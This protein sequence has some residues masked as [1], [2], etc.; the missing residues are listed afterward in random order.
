MQIG[1]TGGTGFI[2]RHLLSRLEEDHH[3]IRVLSRR[4]TTFASP[5]VTHIR[6]QVSDPT[7][8]SK[9]V[10]ACDVVIHLAGIN[11]EYGSQTYDSVH[12][13]GT[14][15]VI[16]ACLEASVDHLIGLSYLRARP[17]SGSGYLESKWVSEELIRSAPIPGTVIK[18]PAVF[19]RGD[20]L[21]THVARWIQTLPIVPAVGI[22]GRDL[23]PIAVED[24][25]SCLVGILHEPDTWPE[26]V[27]LLG[28]ETLSLQELGRRVGTALD[29]RIFTVPTPPSALYAG[30]YL[31]KY[32]MKQ[33]II[34]PAGVRMITEGM[35][36]P[37]PKGIAQSPPDRWM[38]RT[39]PS[40]SSIKEALDS[41][42]RY[43][44]RDLKIG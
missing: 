7:A 8:V 21:L 23:R 9:A 5:S 35:T 27:A 28:P 29:T 41:P 24:L 16:D 2:G 17:A 14:Q 40:V 30:S 37:A 34:T 36:S 38:P 42:R 20:Q 13:R 1:I 31:Q 25:I 33:P 43:G 39:E 44:I 3:T 19:G 22:H 11:V 32:V 15:T 26:T 10:S 18:P 4:E 6:G 12:V